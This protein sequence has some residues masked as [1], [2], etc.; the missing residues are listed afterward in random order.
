MWLMYI[1][2]LEYGQNTQEATHKL[3]VFVNLF[4]ATLQKP[5]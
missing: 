1:S 5:L 3:M 2:Q 4:E